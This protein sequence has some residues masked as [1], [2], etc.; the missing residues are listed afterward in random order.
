VSPSL[1]GRLRPRSLRAR[2]AVT[3]GVA[4]VLGA[5]VFL[6]ISRL[7]DQRAHDAL[8]QTMSEQ[9]SAVALAVDREGPSG[10]ARAAGLLPDT[11]IVVRQRGEVQ[12]W[13]LAVSNFDASAT[14]HRGDIDVLLQRDVDRGLVDAWLAPLLVVLAVAGLAALTWFLTGRLSRRLRRSAADLAEHAERVADGDLSSRAVVSDDE[15]GRIAGAFNAMTERLEQ[16][17]ARERAFLADV[18]HE[19]RTPVTAI[20]GFA[21]ALSDGTART[22]EDRAEAAGFIREEAERLHVLVSDLRRLTWL[23]LDPPVEAAPADLAELCRVAAARIAARAAEKRVELVTPDGGLVAETDGEHVATILDNLLDNALR[24]TPAG[25]TVEVRCAADGG[26]AVLTVADTGPGIPAEH[27]PHV[28][29]RLYRVEPA[30][31]R[32]EGDGSG[33]GL[34]IVRRA[35]ERLGGTAEAASP[36]GC[37]AVFTVR[38]PGPVRVVAG[39]AAAEVPA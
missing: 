6:G 37:G 19:L 23:E 32:A 33:L 7:L 21:Q 10:A 31:Q 22:E 1:A 27:L 15:L 35:A 26:G 36:P 13:N 20:E 24:H 12:Y 39:P 28:F 9:A 11:R 18:A 17:D 5:L 25:G 16:A 8:Q 38:L 4:L 2:I 30:R 14:A 3:T 34:A 29:E